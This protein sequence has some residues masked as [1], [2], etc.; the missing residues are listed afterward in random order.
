MGGFSS[1]DF[2]NPDQNG[3]VLLLI[4]RENDDVPEGHLLRGAR[5]AR[6]S[7]EDVLRISVGSR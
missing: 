2:S 5:P 3:R 7:S 6:A 1:P 4:S